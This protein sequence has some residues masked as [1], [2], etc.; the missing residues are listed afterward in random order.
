MI[1]T[2]STIRTNP[3]A[4]H[5]ECDA[6]CRNPLVIRG[7]EQITWLVLLYKPFTED[8]YI[9]LKLVREKKLVWEC[10]EL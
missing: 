8:L 9:C 7:L 6:V 1:K 3:Y 10:S 2:F 4:L 5:V